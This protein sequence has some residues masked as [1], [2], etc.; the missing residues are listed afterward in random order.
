M[1]VTGDPNFTTPTHIIDAAAAAARAGA[2]GYSPGDG[3]PQLR[4]ALAAKLFE[5]NGIS[6]SADQV[7]VTTGACGGL[8]TTLMMLLGHGD[9]ILLPDPGWSNYAAMVHVLGATAVPYSLHPELGWRIDLDELER[10]ITPHTQAILVNSPNNPTG[11][12]ES[13]ETLERVVEIAQRHDLWVVSDEAYDE[14][15]FDARRVAPSIL[16]VSDRVINVFSFSKTYAMTGWRIGYVVGP[17]P[18]I[19]QLSLHQ[20]PVVSC[21]SMISQHAALAA[22]AGPQDCVHAMVDAYRRRRDLVAAELNEAKIPFV[23][24]DGTFF[25][26]ID[27]RGSGLDS[28]TFARELLQREQVGTVPGLAFGKRGEGFVRITV[29]ASDEALVA[30]VAGLRNALS[31]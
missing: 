2:T 14:L 27:I 9:E 3:L 18:F 31:A 15:V 16:D 4:E 24:P 11:S 17:R 6:A 10:S 30:G 20:E 22:L 29:A 28:W 26:M 19:R 8:Y 7:C 1:L 23:L 25:L 21:A 5:R 13:Q 12:V